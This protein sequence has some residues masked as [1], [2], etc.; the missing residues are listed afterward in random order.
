MIKQLFNSLAEIA[1]KMTTGQLELVKG[2]Q[3]YYRKNKQLSE[4]QLNVLN[5]ILKYCSDGTVPF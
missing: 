5:E 1:G 3:K 2:M 4:K